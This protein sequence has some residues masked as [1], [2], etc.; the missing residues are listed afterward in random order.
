MRINSPSGTN[1]HF[2]LIGIHQFLCQ[3][4]IEFIFFTNFW[5]GIYTGCY[6]TTSF[7]HHPD[8]QN[9]YVKVLEILR[10]ALVCIFLSIWN[11]SWQCQLCC[12]TSIIIYFTQFKPQYC[13]MLTCRHLIIWSIKMI[14]ILL[15]LPP[16]I[17][18]RDYFFPSVNED[19]FHTKY[20]QSQ[21]TY[22]RAIIQDTPSDFRITTS[23]CPLLSW[24]SRNIAW[25]IFMLPI[26]QLQEWILDP[27]SSK[28]ELW[29]LI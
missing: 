15:R 2:I 19:T 21:S 24:G 23:L 6:C 18:S 25:D 4:T 20:Q 1:L 28:S 14:Q 26:W 13:Q 9:I 8:I 3:Q 29:Q 5:S 12:T 11:I 17:T 7:V 22:T 27:D 16:S 10:L